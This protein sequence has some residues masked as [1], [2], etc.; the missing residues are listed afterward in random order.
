MVTL[1]TTSVRKALYRE[2][3]EGEGMR[4]SEWIRL[5]ADRRV[6]Q[7]TQRVSSQDAR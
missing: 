7:Q 2:V 1:R 5:L 6:R 4:L 3:A